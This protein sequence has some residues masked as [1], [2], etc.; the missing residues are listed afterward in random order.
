[1]KPGKPRLQQLT[2]VVHFPL[3][4]PGSAPSRKTI[5]SQR[6]LDLRLIFLKQSGIHSPLP[7]LGVRSA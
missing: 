1:V 7:M 4:N 3:P 2:H 5:C 6:C